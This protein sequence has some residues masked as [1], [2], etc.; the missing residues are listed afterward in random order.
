M[1]CTED[2]HTSVT[3]GASIE[4]Q[5]EGR[6]TSTANGAETGLTDVLSEQPEFQQLN[7][8]EELM[9]KH[10]IHQT[11]QAQAKHPDQYSHPSLCYKD[12]SE[13]SGCL[14]KLNKT[15]ILD[16]GMTLGISHSKLTA[17]MNSQNFTEDVVAAWLQGEEQKGTP[18]W[19]KLITALTDL[20]LKQ[21]GIS[22]EIIRTSNE[23]SQN[24]KVSDT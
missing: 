23:T 1:F 9:V 22:S 14:Q 2:I 18:T 24:H 16:L 17:M 11:V 20:L 8:Q 13:I 4:L 6:K 19:V 3:N 15:H 10:Y 7:E 5:P 12:I 21:E